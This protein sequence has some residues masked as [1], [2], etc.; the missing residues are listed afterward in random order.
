MGHKDKHNRTLAKRRARGELLQRARE[1]HP[2]WRPSHFVADAFGFHDGKLVHTVFHGKR[3]IST[4]SSPVW[5]EYV[6]WATG[7]NKVIAIEKPRFAQTKRA[8]TCLVC[9]G[10]E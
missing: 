8:V 10:G 4:P 5:S 7:C 6:V 2:N 9:V 1:S 3:T